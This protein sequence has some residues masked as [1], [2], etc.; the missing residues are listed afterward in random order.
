MTGR[1]EIPSTLQPMKNNL[2]LFL[3]FFIS[4]PAMFAQQTVLHPSVVAR[5][6]YF[7]VSPPLRD[8]AVQPPTSSDLTWKD[9]IVKNHFRKKD[10]SADASSIQNDPLRQEFFGSRSVDTTIQNFDGVGNVN[11][12][13]PPDTHGDVG[14]NHYFQVVNAA[15]KVFSKTGATLIGPSNNN[16][17]WTGMPNNSNDGDAVVLYDEQADRWLFTQFSLPNYPN[18]PFFQMIAVSQTPDPTGTW[19]RWQ[20]NFTD[21]PDYPKFGVWPDGYYM[22]MN[23]FSAGAGNYVGTGAVAFERSAMLTGSPTAQMVL[24]LVPSSNEAF[25][26]LPSDCD[27]PFPPAGTP[28]TYAYINESPYHLG[29]WDFHADW[30]NTANATFTALTPVDVETFSSGINSISQQGTTKKLDAITDR[31]MYRLQYRK[32]SDH[33][34]LVTNHTVNVGSSV[35]GVRWYELRKTGTAWAMYQQGTYSPDANSRWMASA[36]MD[37]NGSIALGYSVSSSTMFPAIRYTG[38]LSSDPLNTMTIAE[39]TI[40]NGGGAQTGG[41]FGAGRWGDYSAMSVDPST[42]ST[43]WYTTEYYSTTSGTNW[44]T[45][46]GSFQFAAP[47]TVT[48]SAAPRRFCMGDTCQLNAASAG[49]TGTVTYSWTSD[50]PG[51]TSTLQNPVVTPLENTTYYVSAT[52]NSVTVNDSVDVTVF[53]T[54]TVFAGND[55]IWCWYVVQE[56]VSGF[57]SVN[58]HLHWTTSGDGTFANDTLLTTQYFVGDGDRAN[59]TVTLYLT[60]DPITPC[61]SQV[62]DE[63]VILIDACT[64]IGEPDGK[65]LWV[66]VA[67][68]P[69]NGL[70]TVT[71]H[72]KTG[73][74]VSIE[75]NDLSGNRVYGSEMTISAGKSETVVDLRSSPKGAYLIRIRNGEE[76]IVRKLIVN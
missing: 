27:G 23:R 76:Q 35:A 71:L 41:G 21:M 8:M 5:A 14:P 49:S 70:F 55:T 46:I 63:K 37:A 9:G 64:G 30:T 66:T 42:P 17:I 1:P 18:G 34:S 15:F 73:T 67:P 38:R 39:G 50:P 60:A 62:T 7:D 65:K 53:P 31:L 52:D 32:F 58:T 43:F 69:G 11:G 29:L 68:N 57:V 16:T 59:G 47:F 40:I 54:A 28:N 4:V 12:Y 24:F 25:G 48:A 36:A 26:F 20:F 33:Q 75:V 13:V 56:T 61:L 72:A 19:Y 51:F 44:K 3:L 45:R 6:V 22:S 2:L 10:G 74:Q